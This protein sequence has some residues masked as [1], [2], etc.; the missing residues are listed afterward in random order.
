MVV[1]CGDT[2][3]RGWRTELDLGSRKPLEDHH[4]V[5]TFVAGCGG[6]SSTVFIHLDPQSGCQFSRN[7]NTFAICATIPRKWTSHIL[8]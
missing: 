4:A 1:S 6:G 8:G 7:Q 2:G 5:A 3:E